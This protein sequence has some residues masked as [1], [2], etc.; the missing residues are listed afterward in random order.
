MGLSFTIAAGP[1]QRSYS[2]VRVPRDSWPYF[3]VSDSRLPPTWRTRSPYL[4]PP[5]T[6][7]SGYTPGHWVPFSWPP[8]IRRATVEVF[9]PSSTRGEPK[10]ITTSNRS[11]VI[12]CLFVDTETCLATLPSNTCPSPVE[13]IT[14]RIC[15][16][17][18]CLAMDVSAVLLWL[19]TSGVQSSCHNTKLRLHQ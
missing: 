18:R 14:S 10:E 5:G 4:Y 9:D 6:G 13:S 19:H 15:L 3:T 1:R 12:A 11:C 7:W 17:N 16:P 8:T 2:Q